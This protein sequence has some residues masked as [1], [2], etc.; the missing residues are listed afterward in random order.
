MTVTQADLASLWSRLAGA[1]AGQ[2]RFVSLRVDGAGMLDVHA[3]LRTADHSPCLLFDARD[4]LPDDVEFEVGGMRCARAATDTGQ[5]LV[6][7]LEDSGRRDL[8]ATLGA[9]VIGYAANVSGPKALPAV[10]T[11]LDAWRL[12]LRS[13]GD[14]MTRSEIIG[15][16]GELRILNDLLTDDPSLLTTWKAPDDGIHDFEHLG[17]ALEVKA[18]TG[19]GSRVTISRLDQLDDGGLDRLDLVHVRLYE[20]PQGESVDD[21]V[22]RITAALPDV[23]AKRQL[24]NALLRRGLSPDDRRARSG[25]RT[26]LQQIVVYRVDTG[27]PRIR[28]GDVPPAILDVSYVLDLG[29]L[30]SAAEP[31]SSVMVSL[32]RRGH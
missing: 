18:T 2:R 16:I 15:L 26:S 14:G 29:Q 17:Q 13:I 9:D 6:L 12:F 11:R 21:L 20:T 32:A 1:G 7:S 4:G 27:V 8:F 30:G 3:A 19:P 31:W 23:E 28:R 22:E 24:S 5:S 25:L 10:L